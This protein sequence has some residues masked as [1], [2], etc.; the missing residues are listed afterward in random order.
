MFAVP[1]I[2]AMYLQHSRSGAV[3]TLSV[4]AHPNK[5]AATQ[6]RAKNADAMA[7]ERRMEQ[8]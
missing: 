8:V 2:W 6:Q 5:G 4:I 1:H 3:I 7:V